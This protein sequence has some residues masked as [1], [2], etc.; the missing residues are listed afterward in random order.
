MEQYLKRLE[1]L[2]KTAASFRGVERAFALQ[3]GREIRIFVSPE[4]INDFETREL[5]RDIAHRIESD[6]NYPGEIKVH[7]I[8]ETRV[9]EYAR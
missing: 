8:R 7:V 4:Q 1:D 9:I 5:A 3:A 6:L 2:E